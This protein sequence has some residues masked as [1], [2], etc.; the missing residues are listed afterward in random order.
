MDCVAV[1]V[2]EGVVDDRTH[3]LGGVALAP[4]F[5]AEPIADLWRVA[6]DLREAA[7]ADQH[8]I[9]QGN[10]KYR[11]VVEIGRGDEVLG[12]RHA[13]RM[14]NACRV[15]GDAAV[16]RQHCDRFSVPKPR[17]TQNQPLGLEDGN[18]S[19]AKRIRRY[20]LQCHDTGLL[21]E[22]LK[23]ETV[24]VSPLKSPWAPPVRN[25]HRQTQLWFYRFTPQQ[26]PPSEGQ[27]RTRGLWLWYRTSRDRK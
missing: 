17:R 13:V 24:S 21:F 26:P 8:A 7:S 3:G 1:E 14:R 20:F 27:R 15:L 2:G 9:A 25:R 12:V 23:G 5:D 16:V 22:M 10:E 4:V 11:L 6:V 18:T 19:L